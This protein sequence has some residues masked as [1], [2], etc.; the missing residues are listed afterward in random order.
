[1]PTPDAPLG[2]SCACGH[3]RFAVTAPFQT[4]GYCHCQRCQRRSGT[5]STLNGTV[6]ADGFQI[7][8]GADAVRTWRPPAGRPKAFCEHCGGHVYSGDPEGDGT[9]G[10]RLGA[11][12]GDPGM[13][14]RWRQWLESSPEWVEIPDDGVPRFMG[15]RTID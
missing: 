5:L 12:D 9:V 14:P 1:M 6:A 4:A 3:V 8:S 11:V 13:A 2:G 7:V 10:I 15:A